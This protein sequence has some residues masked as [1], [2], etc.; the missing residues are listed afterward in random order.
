MEERKPAK[1]SRTPGSDQAPPVRRRKKAEP[2]SQ[3][4]FR[5]GS[6]VHDLNAGQIHLLHAL[7]QEYPGDLQGT[8]EAKAEL[9]LETDKPGLG[10]FFVYKLGHLHDQQQRLEA[11]FA[12]DA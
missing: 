3:A 5:H 2:S 12:L 10:D 9:V 7:A 11:L 4:T 8:L 1:T 6:E